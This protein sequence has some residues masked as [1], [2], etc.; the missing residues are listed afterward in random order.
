MLF[1]VET[2][3]LEKTNSG[4]SLVI[5]FAVDALETVRTRF[6]LFRFEFR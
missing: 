4:V 6:T 5:V 2:M 3:F 1:F